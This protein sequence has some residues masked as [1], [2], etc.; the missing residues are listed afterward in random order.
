MFYAKRGKD[1]IFFDDLATKKSILT[2]QLCFSAKFKDHS[3]HLVL[4][5]PSKLMIEQIGI[6]VFFVFTQQSQLGRTFLTRY[7]SYFAPKK[8]KLISSS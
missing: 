2:S 8:H 5:E 4:I 1:T 3:Q 7:V 6:R